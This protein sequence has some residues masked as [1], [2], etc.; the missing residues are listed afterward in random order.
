MD[1]IPVTNGNGGCSVLLHRL[2]DTANMVTTDGAG[3][4]GLYFC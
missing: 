2:K 3:R 4:L 1:N